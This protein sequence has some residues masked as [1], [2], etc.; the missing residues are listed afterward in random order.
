M[1]RTP[2]HFGLLQVPCLMGIV[3]VTPDS[4][5]DGGRFFDAAAAAEQARELV[6]AGAGIVDL[7]AEASSF[8]REEIEPVAAEEQIGRLL[9]VLERLR[10][11]PEGVA[12]SIDTR[13]A[14]VA[15]AILRRRSAGDAR[16]WIINDVSAGMHDAAI[17][18]T[19]AA[20]RAAIVL[21]HMSPG[22]PATPAVDDPDIVVT[23]R[24]DLAKRITA[25]KWAGIPAERVAVDPG[26]GFGKTMADNWRLAFWA[27]ETV[28]ENAGGAVVVLGASRKRF[29]ETEPPGDVGLPAAWG[30]LVDSL[31]GPETSSHAR[32]PA[33]AALTA[34]TIRQGVPIHRVHNV[35]L[36]ARAMWELRK[37]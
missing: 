9:P 28:P 30:D 36:A 7:G 19:V 25:A 5:S 2:W 12:I 22:F 6:R 4:F 23:V 3:N 37:I 27:N 21:M 33:S 24:A 17:L 11:L 31:R 15:E 26:I 29:L 1:S 32:D 10:D 13:S 20:H 35:S 8:F 14:A 18:P 34:L 16:G